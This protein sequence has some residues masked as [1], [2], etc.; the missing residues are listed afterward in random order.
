MGLS[1]PNRTV[2]LAKEGDSLVGALPSH[3]RAGS[4]RLFHEKVYFI[5]VFIVVSF[6]RRLEIIERLSGNQRLNGTS[7][8]KKTGREDTVKVE[9]WSVSVVFNQ[10]GIKCSQWGFFQ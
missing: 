9:S 4:P 5:A 6:P 8:N 2:K 1:H 7:L 10:G 3:H